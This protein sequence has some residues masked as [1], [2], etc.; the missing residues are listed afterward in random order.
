M[1]TC[2]ELGLPQIEQVGLPAVWCSY[3]TIHQ[4][5]LKPASVEQVKSP[6]PQLDYGWNALSDRAGMTLGAHEGCVVIL[7]VCTRPES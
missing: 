6:A 1:Q 3:C 2:Q 5:Q 7:L 4:L